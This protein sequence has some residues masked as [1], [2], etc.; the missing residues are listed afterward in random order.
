MRFQIVEDF[1]DFCT[2]IELSH[3]VRVAIDS[4]DTAGKT[5]LADELTEPIRKR[6]RVVILWTIDSF[7][8]PRD[9]RYQRGRD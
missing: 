7:H 4:I 1:A 8:N 5:S 2:S 9:K 3:P 6:G